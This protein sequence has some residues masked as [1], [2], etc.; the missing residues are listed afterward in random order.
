VRSRV[1]NADRKL[2]ALTLTLTAIGVI[3]VADASA[4]AAV[5]DFS[6]KF[7][8]AK[9][10]LFSAAAGVLLLVV[11]TNIKYSLWSKVSTPLF[12]VS[13]GLLMLIFIPG[14]GSKV[15]G[16]KRWITLGG[17][18]IQPSE[19]AKLALCLFMAKISEKPNNTISQ[20]VPLILVAGLV[21]LQPD[22]GTTIVIGGIGMAQ[23]FVSGIALT[24]FTGA[25]AMSIIAGFILIVASDYRKSRFLTFLKQTQDPLGK[26]YHMRQILY[27]L[28]TGGLFG[29]GLG[30]SRQKYLFLPETATDSIF[31][32]IA[33]ET[34]FFGASLLLL[35]LFLLII[36]GLYI[37]REAPD[38]FSKILAVGIVAWIGGQTILNI[39]S[40]VSIV[41][42]TGIPLP[43]ISYGGSSLISILM[44]IGILLNISKYGNAKSKA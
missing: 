18:S 14:V 37:A 15:L 16:A 2:L 22:L 24:Q 43:L 42:L 10:Q 33:E 38:A 40:M 1:K 6:D 13:L 8:F 44:A 4:P 11:F 41:P 39:G 31:A 3:A 34:G 25:I 17:V 32:I 28:G 29:V 5:R 19:F 27:A 20:F 21:M 35:L 23:I 26:G 30:Q 36:R 7:Y 12:F 9:Q